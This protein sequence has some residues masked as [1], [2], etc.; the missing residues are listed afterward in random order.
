MS[1][2]I[3]TWAIFV[4]PDLHATGRNGLLGPAEHIYLGDYVT[5][6]RA[7]GLEHCLLSSDLGQPG[8]PLHADGWVSFFQELRARGLTQQ[9]I[10]QLSKV[11]PAKL[12]NLP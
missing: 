8:N 7:V 12:L 10:D 1:G 9:E 5:A 11:N 3:P 6:I 4:A 2:L